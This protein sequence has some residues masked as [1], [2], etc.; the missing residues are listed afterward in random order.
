MSIGVAGER[1]AGEAPVAARI[2]VD[3][4]QQ[5]INVLAR[6]SEDVGAANGAGIRVGAQVE[7]LELGCLREEAAMKGLLR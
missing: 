1:A 4:A 3:V 6:A 5:I 2:S 7:R